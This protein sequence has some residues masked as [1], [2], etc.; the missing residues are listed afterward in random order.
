MTINSYSQ[1]HWDEILSLDRQLNLATTTEEKYFIQRQIRMYSIN[2]IPIIRSVVFNHRAGLGDLID[3][4][5]VEA[6]YDPRLGLV[7][8]N[9]I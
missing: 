5:I 6:D 1:S 9:S 2:V 3:Y 4:T 7:L 8:D